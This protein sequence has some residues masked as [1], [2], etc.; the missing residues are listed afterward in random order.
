MKCPN[1]SISSSH[2]QTKCT[3][4]WTCNLPD[5]S[6]CRVASKTEE[7]AIEHAPKPT[8]DFT[9]MDWSAG[10]GFVTFSVV[11]SKDVRSSEASQAIQVV[12]DQ[13]VDV[14][15]SYKV[16]CFVACGNILFCVE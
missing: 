16:C 12:A 13:T 8:V 3:C 5:G 4:R 9:K 1:P 2:T 15:L 7:Y 14:S 11:V 10:F 6:V